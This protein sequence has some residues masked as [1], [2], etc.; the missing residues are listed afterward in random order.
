MKEMKYL[1]HRAIGL[2]YQGN[3]KN[4]NYV[5]LSLGT[6]PTAY[7]EIPKDHKYY[8]LS[9]DDMNIDCH[10]GLTYS[11]EDYWN[12]ETC[13]NS[14]RYF[15]GWDYAHFEDYIGTEIVY[16]KEFQSNGKKWTTAEI[17]EEVKEAIEQL[18][19]NT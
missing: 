19:L 17:L 12:M 4:F 13:S 18:C 14:D 5:I 9:Y 16:P 2:L 7:V 15:I 6:H 11:G 1:P 8:G 10:G 3:Y